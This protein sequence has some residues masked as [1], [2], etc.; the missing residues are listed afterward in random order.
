MSKTGLEK[1]WREKLKAIQ[2]KITNVKDF[3][4]LSDSLWR[5]QCAK[6]GTMTHSYRK[7][8]TRFYEGQGVMPCMTYV[9]VVAGG[10]MC[11]Y[12]QALVDTE[13]FGLVA[14]EPE[15]AAIWNEVTAVREKSHVEMYKRAI[16][17]AKA[18]MKVANRDIAHRMELI[19]KGNIPDGGL[20]ALK[21]LGFDKK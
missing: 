15:D 11:F 14:G 3:N 7:Y 4:E 20:G 18:L 2:R 10:E 6:L 16:S 19:A 12:I 21:N 8:L 1:E 17:C 13:T 9:P 5:T